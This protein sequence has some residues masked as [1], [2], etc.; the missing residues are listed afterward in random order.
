MDGARMLTAAPGKARNLIGKA[1]VVFGVGGAIGGALASE[2][3]ERGADV[4]LS[5]RA[6]SHVQDVAD[7]ISG[8]G[9]I[10]TV[11][12][13]DALDEAEVNDYIDQ[14]AGA[15]GRIDVVFNAMGP[16][17]LEYG[18][19]TSTM[20]L[21]VEKFM[22]PLD[23]IVRSQFITARSAARHLL[24]QRSGVVLFLSATPSRGLSPNTAA[25]GSAYGAIESLTRCLA[26]ELGPAGVRVVCVRSMGMADTRTMQQTY[27]LG[28]QDMGIP[29]AKIRTIIE[30]RALLGRSPSVAETAQL[31]AFL[32][33]D[34]AT[35]ITGAIINSSCGQVLD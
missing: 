22:L 5:G 27:E 2:L 6:K 8:R 26:T 28:G 31:L 21:P 12:E 33:S 35:A 32:A 30:S 15:A 14:V 9:G 13:V 23:T 1:A 20:L 24:R 10:A 34:E 25:I 7:G 18:N 11:A 17:P 3:A 19:A 4:F 16:Q 29:A